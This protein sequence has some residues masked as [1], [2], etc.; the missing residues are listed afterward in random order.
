MLNLDQLEAENEARRKVRDSSTAAPWRIEGYEGDFT[1]AVL[2]N[3]YQIATVSYDTHE[4]NNAEF[5]AHARN[6]NAC[7]VIEQLIAE[8][9][10]LTQGEKK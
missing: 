6:D 9:R 7:E 3:C 4:H 10:R 1:S 5:I 8:V 2:C